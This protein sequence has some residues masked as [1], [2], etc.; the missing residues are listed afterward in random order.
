MFW[1]T[2][3]NCVGTFIKSQVNMKRR[4]F[5]WTLDSLSLISLSIHMPI[6][7]NL[8]YYSSLTTMICIVYLFLPLCFQPVFFQSKLCL[9]Y[10]VY[11]WIFAFYSVW[12]LCLLYLP[13]WSL[14]SV[15][16]LLILFLLY[17]LLFKINVFHM[18]FWFSCRNFYF[19]LVIFEQ[20][21]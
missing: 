9:L 5:F 7:C 10:T 20:L 4:G 21:L 8:I 11:S 3:L 17:C 2:V 16:S 6:P 14:F 12:P 18:P 15:L 13:S 19:F 1:Y